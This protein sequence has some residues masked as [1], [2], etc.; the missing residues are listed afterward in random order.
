VRSRRET[1]SVVA[2]IGCQGNLTITGVTPDWLGVEFSNIAGNATLTNITSTDPGDSG[3][4]AVSIV[5]NTIGRNLNCEN[6]G[7]RLTGGAFPG[8]FNTVGHKTTGE[9]VGLMSGF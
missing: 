9:C 6:L 8:E 2:S 1:V 3:D 5:V 4:A 7:P